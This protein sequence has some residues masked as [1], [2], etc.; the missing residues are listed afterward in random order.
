[1][2]HISFSVRIAAAVA[3]MGFGAGFARAQTLAPVE[4]RGEAVTSTLNCASVDAN[5]GGSRNV[6]TFTG[7]CTRL[8]VR[9]DNNVIKA[10]FASG[11]VIDIEGNANRLAITSTTGAAPRLHLAGTMA[12]VTTVPGALPPDAGSAEL[13]GERH[14]LT[15]GCGAGAATLAGTRN[16]LS[17]TGRCRALTLRGEASV[18]SAELA[19]AA[20]ILIEG[21]AIDVI[22]TV[23]GGDIAPSVTI[24]GMGSAAVRAGRESALALPDVATG[25]VSGTVPVLVRDLDAQIVEPGTLVSLPDAVF[26][27]AGLS[28]G[29][30][31]QLD[32]LAALLMQ[33]NP[34]GVRVSGGDVGRSAAVR[35]RLQSRGIKTVSMQAGG[36]KTVEVLALR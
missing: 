2:A 16:R 10:G 4:I 24:R 8:Q 32:R 31:V 11:A 29:G 21:N 1:M 13:I 28:P 22:Y 34:R 19:P 5:V 15:L 27:P 3:A 33:I 14:N 26:A 6:V 25:R 20:Q 35:A 9:G 18:I 12:E 7:A 17:L 23:A 36:G 30:E